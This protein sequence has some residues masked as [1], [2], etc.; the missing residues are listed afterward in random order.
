MDRQRTSQSF[1]GALSPIGKKV[2]LYPTEQNQNTWQTILAPDR[3]QHETGTGK[4]AVVPDNARSHHARA[5]TG[6]HGPGRLL[7]RIT[8]IH[9]P[10]YA[11]DHN[12]AGHVRNTA[13]NNTATIS[14]A[15]CHGRLGNIESLI[16]AIEQL[17]DPEVAEQ[18][19]KLQSESIVDMLDEGLICGV[20]R[21]LE[22]PGLMAGISGMALSALRF[23]KKLPD[24]T[25]PLVLSSDI[26]KIN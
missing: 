15:L 3:L 4:I 13:R 21:G 12:P 5:L 23:S 22:V 8:P 10:P 1:P 9:P 11:P 26:P 17:A 19:Q 2:T 6:L 20:P 18:I 24:S 25:I 16:V 7:E 14:L